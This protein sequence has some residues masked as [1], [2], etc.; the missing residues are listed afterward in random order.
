MEC[1]CFKQKRRLFLNFVEKLIPEFKDYNCE[2]QFV[3]L[4]CTDNEIMLKKL[5]QF[6]FINFKKRSEILNKL[7]SD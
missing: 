5:G 2:K 7:K 1:S 3:E 6:I 4:V